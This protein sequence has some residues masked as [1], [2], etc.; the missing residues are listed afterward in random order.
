MRTASKLISPDGDTP[1][2]ALALRANEEVL[3]PLSQDLLLNY[4][5][6]KNRGG[7]T[8]QGGP[9]AVSGTRP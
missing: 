3:K 9:E 2:R 5:R 6:E 7:S 1:E 4:L 8:Y